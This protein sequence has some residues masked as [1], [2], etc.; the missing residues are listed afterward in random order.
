MSDKR[1]ALIQF[2][3]SNC[4]WE[5]K[6]SAEVVGL[7]CD[8]FRWNRDPSALPEYDG[9]LIGGGFSYQ[10]RVRSG[11]IA[12]KQPIMRTVFDQVVGHGKPVL[13]ICNGAQVLIEAGLIPG[14]NAGNVEM[15][16]APNF[17]DPLNRIAGFCCRWVYL[18]HSIP[19]GRCALTAEIPQGATLLLQTGYFYLVDTTAAQPWVPAQAILY[20]GGKWRVTGNSTISLKAG[21]QTIGIEFKTNQILPTQQVW[22]V[23]SISLAAG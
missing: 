8:V 6:R 7:S 15:G 5:S 18:K 2:P 22:T 17:H 9:Y 20:N 12:T 11:V 23:R 1:I 10:D 14:L 4:E 13:G 21:P 16:L 3:G 19:Q